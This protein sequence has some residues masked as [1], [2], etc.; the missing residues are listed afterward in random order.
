MM[1]CLCSSD[2]TVEKPGGG[3]ALLLRFLLILGYISCVPKLLMDIVA[4]RNSGVAN[5]VPCVH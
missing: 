1:C 4:L 2:Q 5:Y 3:V